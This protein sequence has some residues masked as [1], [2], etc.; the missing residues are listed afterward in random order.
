MNIVITKV[1]VE[2]PK[3]THLELVDGHTNT[4]S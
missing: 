2:N 4:H 1:F 3:K